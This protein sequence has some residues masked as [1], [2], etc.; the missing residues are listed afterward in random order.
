MVFKKKDEK[1]YLDP[2]SLKQGEVLSHSAMLTNK[3]LD[4]VFLRLDEVAIDAW[5]DLTPNLE[6]IQVY[7]AVMKQ[8][9]NNIFPIFN[10]AE[11]VE[12]VNGLDNFSLTFFGF[13]QQPQRDA[14]DLYRML[15]DLDGVHQSVIAYL[16]KR[17]YFF[18]TG[19]RDIKGTAR[20]LDVLKRKHKILEEAEQG[21]AAAVAANVAATQEGEQVV[22]VPLKEIRRLMNIAGEKGAIN[23]VPKV[24]QQ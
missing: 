16:Q 18:R 24:A 10:E 9:I 6:K 8:V 2:R 5:S 21:K 1:R 4:L 3:R 22:E 20:A 14:L 11:N 17:Q 13:I 23:Q 15:F 7:Y 19:E 12:I